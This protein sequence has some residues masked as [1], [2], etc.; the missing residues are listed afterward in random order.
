MNLDR[1][2]ITVSNNSSYKLVKD[3]F[4]NLDE[5]T[6]LKKRPIRRVWYTNQVDSFYLMFRKVREVTLEDIQKLQTTEF[7]NRINSAL[8]KCGLEIENLKFNSGRVPF[9][10]EVLFE[11]HEAYK[12]RQ[13][14]IDNMLT[15]KSFNAVK[16]LI[17]VQSV[18]L[19]PNSNIEIQF[20][21]YGKLDDTFMFFNVSETGEIL[22]FGTDG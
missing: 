20:T 16:G 19:K 21:L 8:I 7:N 12:L 14:G 15:E 10:F 13:A 2:K 22:D 11:H 18:L 5:K 4:F 9:Y 1:N 17:K 6:P 3:Q